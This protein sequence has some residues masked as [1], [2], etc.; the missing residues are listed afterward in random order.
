MLLKDCGD[1]SLVKTAVAK[2]DSSRGTT[3]NDLLQ[4]STDPDGL[5]ARTRHKL[6]QTSTDLSM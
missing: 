1:A 5:V 4:I 6:S 2:K 3:L